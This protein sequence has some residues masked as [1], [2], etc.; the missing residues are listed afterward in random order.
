[1][2]SLVIMTEPYASHDASEIELNILHSQPFAAAYIH[3]KKA[4]PYGASFADSFYDH[5]AN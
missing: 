3:G 2:F 4:R 1:M 5:A